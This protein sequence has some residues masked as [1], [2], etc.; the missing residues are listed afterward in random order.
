MHTM[1]KTLIVGAG[2]TGLVLGLALLQRG[3]PVRI[4]EER[5]GPS[6][7]S[8]ALA[9]HARTLE[10]LAKLGVIAGFLEKGG[11]ARSIVLH[12]GG[13]ENRF[14]LDFLEDTPYP[15]VL[16]LPQSETEKILVEAI[17]KLGGKIEWNSKLVS[18]EQNQALLSTQEKITFDWLIGSD[19]G[20][21]SVRHLLHLPFK[22]YEFQETFLIADIE[23]TAPVAD[24]SPHFFLSKKGL[25]GVIAFPPFYCRLIVPLRQGEE[26][27]ENAHDIQKKL[28]E[29][30]CGEFFSSEKVKWISYFKIHRRMVDR[31][32]LGNCFL[33]GDAA[34]IHSPAGGQGMNTSIQDAFNLAWKLSMVIRGTA[35]ASLLDSYERERLPIARQVLRGTTRFTRLLTIVQKTGCFWILF[36]F[37]RLVNRFFKRKVVRSLTELSYSYKKSQYIQQPLRDMF[38]G[39]PKAGERAPN[40]KLQ[41]GE[42]FFEYLNQ[43]NPVLLLF[44]ENFS[45]KSDFFE[46]LV[47]KDANLKKVYRAQNDSAYFIRPDGVIGYRSRSLKANQLKKYFAQFS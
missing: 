12:G 6:K 41:S 7:H 47:I 46:I 22:G 32:R 21:S 40:V 27:S 28:I 26:I 23:R 11:K 8:K 24:V 37:L 1:D 30:E 18:I 5:E 14:E 33:A 44:A 43:K 17:Y 13:K 42:D 20:R 16:I 35:K 25:V 2:P 29:R 39:G 4:I 9:I 45:F 15:F 10:I 36:F 34:H 19:G 38:W 3:I 31:M